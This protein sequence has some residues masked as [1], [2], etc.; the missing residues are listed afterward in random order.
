MKIA[1]DVMGGDFAPQELI[2]GAKG[3]LQNDGEAGL[4]LVGDEKVIRE[5]WPD[6]PE[7][8]EIYH[9][10]EVI[11]MGEH[12][13]QALR[14]KKNASVAVCASLVKQ[15]KADGFIS[16]GSTGAQMAA[17]LLV[18]GKITGI[19]RPA[20]SVML[21]TSGDKGVL[22]L[23]VGANVDVRPNHLLEFALMGSAYYGKICG[24]ERPKV[25]LLNIGEEE[26]K[27]NE[28]TKAAYELL[29]G[30]SLNFVG[31]VEADHLF[32]GKANVV[33][34]DGFVGNVL[35]KTS[36]GVSENMQALVFKT[37][38]SMG[39]ETV[40]NFK[41]AIKKFSP[42]SPEYSAAPLLGVNGVSLVCHGKSKAPVITNAIKLAVSCSKSNYVDLIT[43]EL[44]K[45][46]Q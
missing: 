44:T 14:K 29:K 41:K 30:S 12:P 28:L 15:G 5:L 43:K 39:E 45:A 19:E 37:A 42:S 38:M 46:Q 3:Y 35:L 4:I 16:A 7:S 40:G 20:I 27:G 31:N 10:D 34:C 33:V 36:E 6:L 26:A 21:P 1:I 13:L 17:S 23:D 32:E 25:G 9:T 2:A 22:L 24:I 8:C 18:L 11:E